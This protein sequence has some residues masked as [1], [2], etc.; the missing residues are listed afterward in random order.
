MRGAAWMLLSSLAFVLVTM[1]VKLLG[2]R[3]SAGAQT[4]YRQLAGVLFL[5][6][7]ILHRG[8]NLLHVHRLPLLLFRSGVQSLGFI[9]AFWSFQLLP[10]ADA[11]ALS[12]TRA[13]WVVPLAVIFLHEKPSAARI[14][15]TLFGFVGVLVLLRPEQTGTSWGQFVAIGSTLMI[16]G[17]NISVKSLSRDHDTVL[18]VIWSSLLGLIV[19]T[20]FIAVSHGIPPLGDMAL[21]GAMGMMGV[22]AQ[23]F[24]IKGLKT[25]DV[26]ALMPIDYSRLIMAAILGWLVFGERITAPTVL[27]AIIIII[28]GVA[29]TLSEIRARGK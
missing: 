25:G 29:L 27:G 11:N 12:F 1:L 8:A 22:A 26:S 20:P 15:A 3:Y 4:F 6:P 21:L 16:A 28:A 14:F 19:T 5:L 10:L 9:L 17:A 23:M 24:F 18:L 2:D 7:A 13:L